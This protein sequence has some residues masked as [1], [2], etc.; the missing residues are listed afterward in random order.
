MRAQHR[1]REL[2]GS[3]SI[4]ITVRYFAS[5]RVALRSTLSDLVTLSQLE[6]IVRIAESLAKMRLAPIATEEHIEEA[7]RIFTVST[8]D[9]INSGTSL[10][11]LISSVV[12]PMK[13][14]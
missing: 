5:T 12:G 14:K 3:N 11:F 2:S 7:I 9:A 8:V 4:P 6:A 1:Q 13:L 10:C